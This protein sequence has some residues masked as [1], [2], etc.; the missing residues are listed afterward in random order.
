M[1]SYNKANAGLII[2]SVLLPIVGYILYFSKKKDE[3]DAA[4][5]YLWSAIAGSIVGLLIMYA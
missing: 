2:L 3:P 4:S 5:Q 1:S